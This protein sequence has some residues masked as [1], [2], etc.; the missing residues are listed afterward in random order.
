MT[1]PP[2]YYLGIKDDAWYID[3]NGVYRDRIGNVLPPLRGSIDKSETVKTNKEM[4]VLKRLY[5][6]DNHKPLNILNK[7]KEA[8]KFFLRRLRY[9]SNDGRSF[10]RAIRI[11]IPKSV[12]GLLNN[13]HVSSRTIVIQKVKIIPVNQYSRFMIEM[14]AGESMMFSSQ[15][16]Q[17]FIVSLPKFI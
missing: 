1:T 2:P 4:K 15:N 10:E 5:L 14:T 17:D 3:L 9:I 7:D 16:L 11:S 6:L 12:E 13:R 8:V